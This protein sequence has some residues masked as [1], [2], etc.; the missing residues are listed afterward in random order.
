MLEAG[1]LWDGVTI[2]V[3]RLN[4]ILLTIALEANPLHVCKDSYTINKSK[5]LSSII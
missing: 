5:E 2:L 4:F 3:N 1:V